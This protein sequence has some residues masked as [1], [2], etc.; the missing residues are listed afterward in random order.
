MAKIKAQLLFNNILTQH[1]QGGILHHSSYQDQVQPGEFLEDYAA[2]LLFATYLYEE[3]AEG[4]CDQVM[5][6]NDQ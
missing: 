6:I 2:L 5:M 4:K 3:T 1:Y